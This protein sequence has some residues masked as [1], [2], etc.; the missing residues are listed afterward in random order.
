MSRTAQNAIGFTP[1]T[2][3]IELRGVVGIVVGDD[4]ML[5]LLINLDMDVSNA[6]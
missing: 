1:V 6:I 5:T 4:V 3:I 2:L